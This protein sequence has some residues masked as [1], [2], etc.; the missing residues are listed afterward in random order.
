MLIGID[1]SRAFSSFV[2]G[3]ENYSYYLIRAML[4]SDSPHKFRLYLRSDSSKSPRFQ[5]FF[6]GLSNAECEMSIVNWPFLWT[7]AGLALEC[8]QRPPDV[9][10]V[11]A[12][13]IPILRFPG[14]KTLVTIH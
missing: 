8:L 14:L 4:Q 12:H 13:T 11:P 3:P 1:A 10:F 6:S 5:S 9:L 7:Q 2:G